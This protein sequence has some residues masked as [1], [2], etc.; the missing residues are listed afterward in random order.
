MNINCPHCGHT[1][2]DDGS[3]AGQLVMCPNCHG[4]FNMP[5][6][7]PPPVQGFTPARVVS[8]STP[9]RRRRS[10]KPDSTPY[11]VGGLLCTLVA[12]VAVAGAVVAH[13]RQGT[14]KSTSNTTETAKIP[15]R[16]PPQTNIEDQSV[17]R[18]LGRLREQNIAQ[19]RQL[20]RLDQER[21]ARERQIEEEERLRQQEELFVGQKR[22]RLREYREELQKLQN[23]LIAATNA[24]IEDMQIVKRRMDEIEYRLK[25]G[26]L[27]ILDS[28]WRRL[29]Q[30]H[31]DQAVR[32]ARQSELYEAKQ[33]AIEREV[34][35]LKREY[36]DVLD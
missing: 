34:S 36:A 3:L 12:I 10:R 26:N 33:L 9:H 8:R 18:E 4:Q 30:E 15:E 16:R 20:E 31:Q 2:T 17:E 14:A 25:Y 27:T 6:V 21:L 13:S 23:Q 1:L 35:Q 5:L 29:Y 32:V 7:E 22:E 11:I 24:Y 19:Q 28:E